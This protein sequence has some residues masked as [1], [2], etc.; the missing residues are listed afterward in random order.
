MARK[1]SPPIRE[2]GPARPFVCVAYGSPDPAAASPGSLDELYQEL[3]KD[4]RG[5][6]GEIDYETAPLSGEGYD[7][8][9]GS[10]ERRTARLL[11]F[12][13][14]V[15]REELVDMRRT[16]LQLEARR[17]AGGVPPLEIDPGY[18]SEYS[19]VRSSLEEDFHRVYLY[20]GVYGEVL[21]SF[22]RM[23]FRPIDGRTPAFYQRPDV[24]TAFNDMRVIYASEI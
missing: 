8:L 9:Y 22:E 2:P 18:V 1:W 21:Y 20:H 6:F 19:V 15:G 12:R 14:Q 4:L 13:R 24:L 5:L 16:T 3:R 11:S 17:Q 23:Q 10:A 7:S